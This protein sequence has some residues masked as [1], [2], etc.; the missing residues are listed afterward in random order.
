MDDAAFARE[1]ECSFDAAIEG[2][3]FASEMMKA[4]EEKRIASL[5]FEPVVKVDTAW[6]IGIDDATAIWFIQ[7]VGRERRLIDYL[8]V[9]SEGLPTI[10][11]RLDRKGY[12]YGRHIMPHD[13]D[14]R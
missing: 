5:P 9:S 4:E 1:Y 6:D 3:Y 11:R 10:A 7:D 13:A 8:E 12:R 14:Y 2:A